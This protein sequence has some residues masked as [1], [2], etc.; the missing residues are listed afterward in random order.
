MV[1][2]KSGLYKEAAF[3][4]GDKQMSAMAN[5]KIQCLVATTV[6]EVGID[7]PNATIIVI[8]IAPSSIQKRRQ[9]G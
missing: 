5:N 1:K 9:Q 6:V 8:E 3:V 7:I 2:S 4:W